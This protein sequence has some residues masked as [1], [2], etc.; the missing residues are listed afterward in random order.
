ME[1]PSMEP[2]NQRIN[3]IQ[4]LQPWTLMFLYV[5][6]SWAKLNSSVNKRLNSMRRSD[7]LG[8]NST[9]CLQ[10][11]SQL[12]L[13]RYLEHNM[14]Y[15]TSSGDSWNTMDQNGGK[16]MKIYSKMITTRY[17]YCSQTNREWKSMNQEW[18]EWMKC[19]KRT[20]HD[21]LFVLSSP[22]LKL[23]NLRDAPSCWWTKSILQW[24]IIFFAN[25]PA[26]NW[27]ELHRIP[28]IQ[29]IGPL[30]GF[31]DHHPPISTLPFLSW[32]EFALLAMKPSRQAS[33]VFIPAR[34][35]WMVPWRSIKYSH[36]PAFLEAP[37]LLWS[38]ALHH[39]STVP[40]V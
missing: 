6:D 18:G 1:L 27:Y 12:V 7:D 14:L 13:R 34:M 35:G 25:V 19:L 36:H 28:P 30:Q 8:W 15:R 33:V 10:I 31:L 2:T 9:T 38:E 11:L 17:S 22:T 4:S 24:F 29:T 20:I 39:F 5:N 3:K 21:D 16:Y 23:T 32:E 37:F 40:W 26:T